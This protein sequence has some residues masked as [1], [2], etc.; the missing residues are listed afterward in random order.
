MERRIALIKNN[1]ET[2]ACNP[3]RI[4][5]I[6]EKPLGKGISLITNTFLK[7]GQFK[8][9]RMA[10]VGGE[11]WGFFLGGAA[12]GWVGEVIFHA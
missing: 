5:N 8:F 10:G 11:G 12:W 9:R 2:H 6:Y 1:N 3:L 4:V 7:I